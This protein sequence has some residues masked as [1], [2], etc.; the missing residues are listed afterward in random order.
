MDWDSAEG[1]PVLNARREL[2]E[3]VGGRPDNV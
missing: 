1:Q 2:T 3:H